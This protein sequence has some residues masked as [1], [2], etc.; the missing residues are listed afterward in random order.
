MYELVKYAFFF[1]L[2]RVIERNY[3]ERFNL[4]LFTS[5]VA[6]I[7]PRN[8]METYSCKTHEHYAERA[9]EFKLAGLLIFRGKSRSGGL[10]SRIGGNTDEEYHT[11]WG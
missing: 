5:H 9:W 3:G 7:F 10:S 4:K 1:S 11:F 2:G 6:R 8:Q